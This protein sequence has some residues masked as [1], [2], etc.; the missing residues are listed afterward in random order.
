MTESEWL[1]C[2][3][4]HELL[5]YKGEKRRSGRKLRLFAVACCRRGWEALIDLRSRRAVEAHEA[6]ADGLI[7]K[8]TLAAIAS[9]AKGVPYN[10]AVHGSNRPSHASNNAAWAVAKF[11]VSL[12]VEDVAHDMG[13]AVD[14]W[15][16]DPHAIYMDHGSG[17]ESKVQANLFR[18]IFGN[19]FQ[20]KTI[21]PAWLKWNNGTIP[22]LAGAIYEEKAFDRLPILGDA[23]E[24]AGCIDRDILD[25]CRGEGMHARGCW[26]VDA[27]LGRR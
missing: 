9:E 24:E 15:T 6:Y 25:H 13:D 16:T 5:D 26:V 2:P 4:V 8:E 7:D 1:T 3:Y 12:R 10:E 27:I 14:A 23:L 11:G 18:D 22:I 17:D 20:T 21:D 19:P